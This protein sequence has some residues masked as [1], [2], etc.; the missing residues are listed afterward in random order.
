M[1]L[2]RTQ[3]I[4]FAAATAIPFSQGLGNYTFYYFFIIPASAVGIYTL[5][6]ASVAATE[7]NTDKIKF[8]RG[9]KAGMLLLPLIVIGIIFFIGP[10]KLPLYGNFDPL[11]GG[12]IP[13]ISLPENAIPINVLRGYFIGTIVVYC[14]WM[15]HAFSSLPNDKPAFVSRA[16]AGFCLL[17]ACFAATYSLT[18]PLIC[19]VCFGLSLLLQKIAPA[20]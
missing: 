16:L 19:L 15:L 4:I 10:A 9:L 1:A 8:S 2:C 20:T 17:D 6:L 18:V 12:G 5:L 7:S 11:L 14:G 3:L 13:T